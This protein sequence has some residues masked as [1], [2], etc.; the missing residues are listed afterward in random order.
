MTTVE[1]ATAVLCASHFTTG[2]APSTGCG[3]AD[4][5]AGGGHQGCLTVHFQQFAENNTQKKGS[6][7]DDKV[8][9]DGRKSDSQYLL[10]SQLEP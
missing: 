1:T 5:A 8:G 2:S 10:E 6:C 3:T 9:G 4:G 7:H